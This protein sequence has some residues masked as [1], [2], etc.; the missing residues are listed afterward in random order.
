MLIA[1]KRANELGHPVVLDPVGVGASKLRT[2]TALRLLN[3]IKFTV[4]R[5]NISEIKTL[6][7]G[8]GTTLT[9]EHL[10]GYIKFTIGDDSPTDLV[11]VAI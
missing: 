6:A 4:I 1:G 7:K 11:S 2:E 5:G 9:F 8:T 3:E 10:A